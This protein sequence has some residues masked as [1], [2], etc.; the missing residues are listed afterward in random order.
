[1]TAEIDDPWA[2]GPATIPSADFAAAVGAFKCNQVAYAHTYLHSPKGGTIRAVVEHA[3]G[4][5][6]WLNGKEIYSA[7]E[8]SGGMGNNYSF[9]RVELAT[10]TFDRAAL[11]SAPETG[12]EPPAFQGQHLQQRGLDRSSFQSASDGSA[13]RLLR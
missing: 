12:L 9:S 10:T 7:P 11:R 2:F 13:D 6:A 5:K 1:M 8:R 4:L 3:H